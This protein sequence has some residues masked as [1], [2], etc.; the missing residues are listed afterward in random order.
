MRESHQ[1]AVR[2]FPAEMEGATKRRCGEVNK[3]SFN[4]PKL[5]AAPRNAINT[6]LHLVHQGADSRLNQ[7]AGD[8]CT[9][10]GRVGVDRLKVTL[11]ASTRT[12]PGAFEPTEDE[13]LLF[14]RLKSGALLAKERDQRT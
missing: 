10:R 12:R 1:L 13:Q 9:L 14:Q 2:L 6:R 8:Q 5:N 11:V 3:A 4:I 7:R